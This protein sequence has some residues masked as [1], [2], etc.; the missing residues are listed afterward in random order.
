MFTMDRWVCVL[1]VSVSKVID[2]LAQL[3]WLHRHREVALKSSS[4]SRREEETGMLVVDAL[5]HQG[6]AEDET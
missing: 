1:V 5:T 2:V 4:R 6:A 3:V